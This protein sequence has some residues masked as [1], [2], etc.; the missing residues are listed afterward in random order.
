MVLYIIIK[1][2]LKENYTS[3]DDYVSYVYLP[4]ETAEIEESNDEYRRFDHMTSAYRVKFLPEVFSDGSKSI[5]L[6]F[7]ET[8]VLNP[9]KYRLI[10]FSSSNNSVLGISNTFIAAKH[11]CMAN[12]FHEVGW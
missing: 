12:T 3:L 8:S 2:F 5:C 9:G 10:Y 6:K 1:F 11:K 7:S 4:S